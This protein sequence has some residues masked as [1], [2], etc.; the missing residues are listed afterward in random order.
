M[1][2][3]GGAEFNGYLRDSSSFLV[4]A[5]PSLTSSNPACRE[6]ASRALRMEINGSR[7]FGSDGG[8]NS[9]LL[10]YANSLA[11]AGGQSSIGSP[12]RNLQMSTWWVV[13]LV[14][15]SKPKWSENTIGESQSL[16]SRRD[17][18]KRS[19]CLCNSS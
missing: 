4:T 19:S 8:G 6:A 5:A 13:L 3:Y 16:L 2:E 9:A 12:E 11:N 15:Q 14:A 7:A 17:E 1:L 18:K 10:K